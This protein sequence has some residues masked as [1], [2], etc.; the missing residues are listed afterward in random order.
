MEQRYR[1]FVLVDP[2][3]RNI[4]GT[5]SRDIRLPLGQLVPY[6]VVADPNA[7]WIDSSGAVITYTTE[8]R[9]L[10]DNPP[11]HSAEWDNNSMSWVDLRTLDQLKADLVAA[12]LARRDQEL[13]KPFTC[14]LGTFYGGPAGRQDIANAAQLSDKAVQ[15]GQPSTVALLRPDG[16]NPALDN[17]QLGLLGLLFGQNWTAQYQHAQDRVLAINAAPDAQTA[18]A[19]AVW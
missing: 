18:T 8:Q 3:T 5:G 9:A 11:S 6:D 17:G 10:R 15:L 1:A 2:S 12:V 14:D 19:A 16:T 13:A 7:Q 4:V